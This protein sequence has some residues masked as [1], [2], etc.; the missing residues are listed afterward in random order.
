MQE[1]ISLIQRAILK[2]ASLNPLLSSL[3]RKVAFASLEAM[4]LDID[5]L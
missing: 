3:M 2:L 1:Y 4:S 5:L